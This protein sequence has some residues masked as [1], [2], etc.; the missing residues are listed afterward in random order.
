MQMFLE[1]TARGMKFIPRGLQESSKDVL[2]ENYVG[3][4]L[5]LI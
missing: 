3:A 2:F 4:E 5:L 1:S